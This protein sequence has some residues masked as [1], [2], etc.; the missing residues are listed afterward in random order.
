MKKTDWKDIAELVGIAAIVCSL[1][2]VGFQLQQSEQIGISDAVANRNE[3]QN[4]NREQIMAYSDVWHRACLGEP[5]E[6]AE[7]HIAAAIS[8]TFWDNM[9]SSWLTIRG[10]LVSSDQ[11]QENLVN[12]VAAQLHSFSGLQELF[13]MRRE[14]FSAAAGAIG[15]AR[16][17]DLFERIEVRVQELEKRGEILNIDVAFCGLL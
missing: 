9:I 15:D 11:L 6:P 8:A 2:F 3:R 13:G 17:G 16:V 1:I 7:R 4:A 10:G 14:M 12:R 5:L